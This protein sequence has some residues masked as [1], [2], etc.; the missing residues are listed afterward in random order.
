MCSRRNVFMKTSTCFSEDSSYHKQKIHSHLKI[1]TW[2]ILLSITA[3]NLEIKL[4]KLKL[5]KY[6]L[7]IFSNWNTNSEIS[8]KRIGYY[9]WWMPTFYKIIVLT[10]W[11]QHSPVS[12][13]SSEP[14]QALCPVDISEPSL[15]SNHQA[16]KSKQKDTTKHSF[17]TW[18]SRY[19]SEWQ[20]WH[21]S[22]NNKTKNKCSLWQY[23]LL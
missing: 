23:F 1:Q 19:S 12:S 17:L 18:D 8:T 5:Q 11:Y 3:A 6:T 14:E 21:E 22:I 10:G 13:A 7:V 2:S 16:E 4:N 15:N 9:K 20:K